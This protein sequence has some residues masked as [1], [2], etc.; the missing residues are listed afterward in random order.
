MFFLITFISKLAKK[1][2]LLIYFWFKI[3]FIKF[4]F[5][6]YQKICIYSFLH[7]LTS[8]FTRIYRNSNHLWNNV[9][10]FRMTKFLIVCI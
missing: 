6:I 5:V 9:V 3:D 2:Y 8:L 4:Q 1:G 7:S 10:A